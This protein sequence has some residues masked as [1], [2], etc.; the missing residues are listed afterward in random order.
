MGRP[1]GPQPARAAGERPASD[2]PLRVGSLGVNG[3]NQASVLERSLGQRVVGVA[4]QG[5]EGTVDTVDQGIDVSLTEE[6]RDERQPCV[7]SARR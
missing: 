5:I 2:P 7:E 1:H 3:S 4:I 6:T